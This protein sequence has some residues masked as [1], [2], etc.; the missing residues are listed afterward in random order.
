[1]FEHIEDLIQRHVSG[2]VFVDTNLLILLLVCQTRPE[3][4]GQY[5]RT[6]EYSLEDF[7]MLS[8]LVQRFRFIL[9][10]PH[11]L[12]EVSKLHGSVLQTFRQ[13]FSVSVSKFE[14]RT[15]SIQRSVLN[16]YFTRLGFTDASICEI[17]GNDL[18]LSADFPLAHVIN[19]NHI[20]V[21]G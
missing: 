7:Q 9:T 13:H 17:A 4:I 16:A 20:R 19:F 3:M 18:D 10:T 2:I 14:E 11:I 21:L 12:T 8:R 15:C 5:Q 1:M 6:K